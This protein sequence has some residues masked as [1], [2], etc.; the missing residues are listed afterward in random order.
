MGV[1]ELQPVQVELDGT[2]GVGLEQIGK[3]LEQLRLGQILDVAVEIDADAA[4][5]AR[6]GFDGLGLQALEPEVLEMRLVVTL[7]LRFAGAGH[8]GVTS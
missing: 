5:G 2:P 3:V 7:E 1:E 4:H 6:V 8:S